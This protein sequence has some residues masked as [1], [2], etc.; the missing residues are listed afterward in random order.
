MS[1]LDIAKI[2]LAS[3]K[4]DIPQTYK[5]M[6]CEFGE[7]FVTRDFASQFSEYASLRNILAHEYLD[8]R[9]ERIERFLKE[10]RG[11]YVQFLFAVKKYL[12]D[13]KVDH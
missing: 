10:S 11:L 4:R 9:W 8:L 7:I 6:L 12:T 13:Q 2:I 3:E 1:A 5:D